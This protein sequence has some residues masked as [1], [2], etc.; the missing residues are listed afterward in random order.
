MTNK[1]ATNNG[2][3]QATQSTG[4][5]RAAKKYLKEPLALLEML[6]NYLVYLLY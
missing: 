3:N 1:P 5:I 6:Q 4:F 2:D